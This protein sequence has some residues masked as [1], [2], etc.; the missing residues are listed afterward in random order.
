MPFLSQAIGIVGSLSSMA[1]SM[2]DKED[3]AL[4]KLFGEDVPAPW[5]ELP[6]QAGTIE[7]NVVTGLGGKVLEKA[8][9]SPL[10]TETV[11][12]VGVTLKGYYYP[13]GSEL[14][15]YGAMLVTGPEL[16]QPK[17]Q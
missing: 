2:S 8:M 10:K 14:I 5:Q 4:P 9:S 13:G 17:G 3:T 7:A 6:E 11:V 15:P 16:V 12:A 1:S